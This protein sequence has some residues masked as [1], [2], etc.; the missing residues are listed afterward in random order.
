MPKIIPPLTDAQLR[1]AVKEAR[2]RRVYIRDGAAPGLEFRAAT[3][4]ARWSLVA[5]LGPARK[6]QRVDIGPYPQISLS[7]AR[8]RARAIRTTP[9]APDRETTLLSLLNTYEEA[10]AVPKSWARCRKTIEHI[11]APLKVAPLHRVTVTDLQHIVDR[12]PSHTNAGAAVRYFRPVLKWAS[13]RQLVNLD[14]QELEQP[15]GAHNP[16]R[17]RT[18]SDDEL[19]KVFAHLESTPYDD[20]IRLLL[21]TVTRLNEVCGSTDA[22]FD[23]P[24]R[25]WTIPGHRRKNGETLVVPLSD[26]AVEVIRRHRATGLP[27]YKY[28]TQYQ[29]KLDARSG[30]TNWTR[31][32]LRRTAATILGRAKTP[33]HIIEVVLGHTHAFSQLNSI[34]NTASYR[35]EHRDALNFLA[36]YYRAL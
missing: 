20:A 11:F 31:H 28:W 12:H 21:L 5:A 2:Q 22:E 25:L 15:R 29:A 9:Y 13:K 3:T 18:L 34:Y 10:G 19:R 27:W 6:R 33:P 30:V 36:E 16:A 4:S 7:E 1:Q 26:D 24:A 17:D 32:D 8:E 23:L 35:S 14:A